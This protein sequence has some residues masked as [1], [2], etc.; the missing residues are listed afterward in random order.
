MR[1]PKLTRPTV[2]LFSDGEILDSIA[3]HRHGAFTGMEFPFRRLR[4][5]RDH[6]E[7]RFPD[8]KKPTTAILVEWRPL[9]FGGRVSLFR[10]P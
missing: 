5:Y 9:H 1:R 7:L 6:V 4:S 10:L 3:L 2:D 8:R